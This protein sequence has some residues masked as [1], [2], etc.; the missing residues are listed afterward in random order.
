MPMPII[1]RRRE[2]AQ[3]KNEYVWFQPLSSSI[4]SFWEGRGKN[5]TTIIGQTYERR[6][7]RREQ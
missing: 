7:G 4:F 2:W 5:C 3:K 6:R 1:E